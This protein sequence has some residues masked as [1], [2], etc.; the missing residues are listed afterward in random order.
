MDST[1]VA[2]H[3]TAL[4]AAVA[5]LA[6]GEHLVLT[7][8]GWKRCTVDGRDTVVVLAAG[9]TL[10][11]VAR[12]RALWTRRP[13]FT[14]GP[15]PGSVPAGEWYACERCEGT[16]VS[17]TPR[18]CICTMSSS[19]RPRPEVPSIRLDPERAEHRAELAARAAPSCARCTG[20]GFTA[21]ECL[22]C[23]GVGYFAAAVPV[24]FTGPGGVVTAVLTPQLAAAYAGAS[25]G[26]PAV[27]ASALVRAAIAGVCDT[28]DEV[29]VSGATPGSASTLTGRWGVIELG[30]VSLANWFGGEFG[31]LAEDRPETSFTVEPLPPLPAVL[32]EVLA[33]CGDGGVGFS[34]EELATGEWGTVVW[35][36]DELGRCRLELGL[37]WT[38]LDAL[39][40]AWD[41]LARGE[42]PPA[43]P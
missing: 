34:R 21:L 30:G 14:P 31:S 1:P 40:S 13:R 35:G 25:D 20:A 22:P 28:G 7:P 11:D 41:L 9:P 3:V 16:G 33:L 24:T 5:Q 18:A 8:G 37:D 39:V 10:A 15:V 36:C 12:C 43:R 19:V 17:P 2:C 4:E 32:T 6:E 26:V 23:S 27:D 29:V 38:T 42:L